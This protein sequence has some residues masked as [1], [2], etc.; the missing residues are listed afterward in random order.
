LP[1]GEGDG[2]KT[3]FKVCSAICGIMGFVFLCAAI[4][5]H[6]RT[7]HE[8]GTVT[9][10]G[11]AWRAEK[12]G[13]SISPV[14]TPI[15]VSYNQSLVATLDMDG[16]LWVNS[17]PTTWPDFYRASQVSSSRIYPFPSAA[18]FSTFYMRS[19]QGIVRVRIQHP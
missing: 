11:T 18:T 16:V 9:R 5:N 4:G 19:K 1:L 10:I 2:V 3:L 7:S 13:I 6:Q 12:T 8:A 17:A 15:E 14:D